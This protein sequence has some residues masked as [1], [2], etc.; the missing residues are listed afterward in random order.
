MTERR[1]ARLAELKQTDVAAYLVALKD[2]D[3]DRWFSELAALRP[4]EHAAER[5]RRAAEAAATEARVEAEAAANRAKECG[6]KNATLAYAMQQDAVRTQLRAPSTAEFPWSSD[7]QV[8]IRFGAD[9]TFHIS[10]YVDAQNAFGA[11]LRARYVSAIR[12]F[13]ES[14]RW[15]VRSVQALQ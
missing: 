8:A 3:K 2:V 13:P 9:C 11:M 4:E 6:K 7:P 14:G 12:L 5:D 15:Q 10:G 1:E